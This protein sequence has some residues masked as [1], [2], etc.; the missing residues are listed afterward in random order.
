MFY[1]KVCGICAST[2]ANVIYCLS[3]I[4]GQLLLICKRIKGYLLTEKLNIC[5]AGLE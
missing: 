3:A 4:T 5:N 1:R 2:F